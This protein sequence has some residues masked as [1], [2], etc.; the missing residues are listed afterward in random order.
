MLIKGIV[1]TDFT[2][3]KEISMFI[4]TAKCN[5]KCCTELGVDISMCQNSS[6]AQAKTYDIS[7]DEIFRRYIS[8]P[9]TKAVVVGGLEPILQFDDIFEL[10][11]VFRENNIEDDIVIYTGYYQ[12]EVEDFTIYEKIVSTYKNIVFKFG[13]Y[14]PNQSPHYD[15][16]LGVYLSSDNQKGVRVC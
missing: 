13:R 15:K 11:Q 10:I 7:T 16:E 5:W 9:I 6:L 3:Y 12:H 4:S 1:D 14:I 8:N 2:N